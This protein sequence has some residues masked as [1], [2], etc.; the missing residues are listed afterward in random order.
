VP[1]LK[2]L[3]EFGWVPEVSFLRGFRDLVEHYAKSS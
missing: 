3:S 2:T 1:N